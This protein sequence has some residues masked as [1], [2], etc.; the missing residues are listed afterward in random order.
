M[1]L[2]ALIVLLS[3]LSYAPSYT[4]K[5]LIV[6]HPNILKSGIVDFYIARELKKYPKFNSRKTLKLIRA[7]AFTE[8]RFRVFALGQSHNEIGLMQLLPANISYINYRLSNAYTIE[9]LYTPSINIEYGIYYFMLCLEKHKR[10]DR[11]I[12]A[13]NTGINRK[14]MRNISYYFRV[15]ESKYIF[16]WM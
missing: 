5:V 11:A 13:Y 15:L 9:Q 12:M 16:R 3:I 14:K 8:S 2:L 7:I 4:N 6:S 10:Y 1:K